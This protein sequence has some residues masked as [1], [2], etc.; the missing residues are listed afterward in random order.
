MT[1]IYICIYIC[2]N[3][4]IYIYIYIYAVSWYARH[5]CS[6]AW[7]VHLHSIYMHCTRSSGVVVFMASVLNWLG[8]LS[9]IYIYI[10]IYIYICSVVVFKASVLN[11]L[12]GL[13]LLCI[14]IYI[15]IYI[16]SVVVCKASMLD[17]L[18]RSYIFFVWCSGSQGIY[19]WLM[20]GPSEGTLSASYMTCNN[21]VH[22]F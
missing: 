10:Y 19:A 11:W 7:G 2:I 18:G 13:S 16:C 21:R 12:G 8:G 15:Y 6:I 3:I 4:H 9:L 22:W 17:W 5:L 14:Y 1:Y 20:G